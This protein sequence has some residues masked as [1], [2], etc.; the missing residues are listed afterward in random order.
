M[1]SHAL[2]FGGSASIPPRRKRGWVAV[3]IVGHVK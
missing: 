3:A 2:L 1:R